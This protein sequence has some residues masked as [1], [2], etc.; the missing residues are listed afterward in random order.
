MPNYVTIWKRLNVCTR[1]VKV[2]PNLIFR[3]GPLRLRIT[4]LVC[5]ENLIAFVPVFEYRKKIVQINLDLR[6]CDLRK[7]LDL[8][9]NK[10]AATKIFVHR[11]FDLGKEFKKENILKT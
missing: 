8:I 11:L 7:N 10:S 5:R 1:N 6:N 2:I 9:S 4:K 3:D